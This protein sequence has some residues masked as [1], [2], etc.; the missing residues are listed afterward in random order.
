[1]TD[2]KF[3]E[4]VYKLESAFRVNKLSDDFLK[5]YYEKLKEVDDK[6]W[7]Q[8]I[9]RIIELEDFFPSIRCLLKY[10]GKQKSL[11]AAGHE[12]KQL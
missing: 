9:E 8:G 10:C 6:V 3:L 5:I 7:L 11:N 2:L 4:G 12:L 1:M